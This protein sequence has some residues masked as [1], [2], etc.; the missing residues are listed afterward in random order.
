M[1]SSPSSTPFVRNMVNLQRMKNFLGLRLT[2]TIGQDSLIGGAYPI[3]RGK[4]NIPSGGR[5]ATVNLL[6]QDEKRYELAGLVQ[7]VG[8]GK[9][10]IIAFLGYQVLIRLVCF[11]VLERPTVEGNAGIQGEGEVALKLTSSNNQKY[12]IFGYAKEVPSNAPR[13]QQFFVKP[14]AGEYFFVPSISALRSLGASG[15]GVL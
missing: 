11:A 1:I 13:K 7:A 2:Y 14:R 9:S 6:N 3:V 15:G 12:E 5:N 8:S 10:P 4:A